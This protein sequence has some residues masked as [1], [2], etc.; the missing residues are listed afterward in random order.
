MGIVWDL[1]GFL[2]IPSGFESRYK[3]G[4]GEPPW[5]NGTGLGSVKRSGVIG[6][7]LQDDAQRLLSF[8]RSP[9]GFMVDISYI[10]LS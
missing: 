5:R 8:S 6:D 3:Y 1:L 4:K 10:Q 7:P 2:N 9:L